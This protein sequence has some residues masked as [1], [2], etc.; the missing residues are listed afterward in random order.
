MK[1]SSWIFGSLA[2]TLTLSAA[3]FAA[4]PAPATAGFSLDDHPSEYLDVLLDGKIAARYMD[5]HDVSTAARRTE[6][7]KPYLH[8]FDAEGKEPITKGPGGL[9][10]HHRAIFIG[11][12]KITFNGKGYDRWHMQNSTKG[13]KPGDIVHEKF[14]N[15]KA[16]PDE[17][18][19]TSLTHWETVAGGEP[20]I[21]EER[22]IT[23]RRGPAPARLLIDF[24]SVLKA[25][26]G[27]VKLDGDPEHSGIQYRP[28]A[29]V[30]TKQTM[31]FFP[32]ERPNAH[33]DLDYPWV[34]E[35]YSLHGQDYSVVEMSHPDDPK[36]THWSAYRDYGRFGA[37]PK[38]EIKAGESLTLK[39]RF[40]VADGKM[41]P[42]DVIERSYD[43]FIG[44]KGPS[45]DP[46]VTAVPAEQS[47][48]PTTK[49]AKAAKP[50]AAT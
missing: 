33:K 13:E 48:A 23:L 47:K 19:F 9:F 1:R 25:P 22:T 39:Y 4:G 30:D 41:L 45:P 44:A 7:Y 20:L 10:P 38:A 43:Q 32:A 12:N 46:K 6:T 36:G 17:A 34:G 15:E 2:A 26:N 28:A 42:T 50:A 16:G 8:V 29:D 21:E 24:T 35:T 31:Y 49:P 14:L 11:W 37:F 40:L 27:D 3:A 18:T 5:A